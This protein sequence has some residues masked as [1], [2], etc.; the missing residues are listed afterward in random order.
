MESFWHL[1][2][3]FKPFEIAILKQTPDAR[4]YSI[5]VSIEANGCYLD[6]LVQG[7]GIMD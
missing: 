1:D 4:V 2:K 6:V 5:S 7:C 3:L